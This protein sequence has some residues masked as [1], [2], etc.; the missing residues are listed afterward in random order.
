MADVLDKKV[1]E[2]KLIWL[3]VEVQNRYP[4][5][6]HDLSGEATKIQDLREKLRPFLVE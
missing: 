6:F 2:K 3:T 1:Y 4:D 5:L